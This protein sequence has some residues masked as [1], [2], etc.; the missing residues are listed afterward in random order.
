MLSL[1]PEK[2][3]ASR[4]ALG[5]IDELDLQLGDRKTSLAIEALKAAADKVTILIKLKLIIE[6]GI[7]MSVAFAADFEVEDEEKPNFEVNDE[8]LKNTFIQV[9]APAIAYPFLRAYVSTITVNSGY[10]QVLLPPVNFQAI[11]DKKRKAGE[12]TTSTTVR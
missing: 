6:E 7:G 11:F 3:R 1:T 2:F 8:V 10:E 9:N 12:V 4:V 5:P